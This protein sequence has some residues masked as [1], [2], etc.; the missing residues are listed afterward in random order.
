M[1][2]F[3]EFNRNS[4]QER[5]EQYQLYPEMA[6]FHVALRE[7]LGEEEYNAFYRAEKESQRFTVP[8]YHQTT[9]KWVHA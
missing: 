4:P 9:S 8:M 2:S 3:Y 7:E 1:R 5:Q 6:L